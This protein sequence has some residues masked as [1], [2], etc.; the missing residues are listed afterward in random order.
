MVMV[1]NQIFAYE[2]RMDSIYF[3]NKQPWSCSH[4]EVLE[5]KY[6][7]GAVYAM[8]ELDKSKFAS[9]EDIVLVYNSDDIPFMGCPVKACS[10]T[11]NIGVRLA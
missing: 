4:G 9:S 8:V 7:N 5:C 2:S 1:L 11:A 10:R 6:E 3:C